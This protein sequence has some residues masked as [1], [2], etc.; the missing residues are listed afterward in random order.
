MSGFRDRVAVITGSGTGI[1]C[2]AAKVLAERGATV[3]VA[4][5]DPQSG[6]QATEAL[7]SAGLTARFIQT[8]VADS[9]SIEAMVTE[10]VAAFGRIDILINN[11]GV[12]I[13]EPFDTLTLEHW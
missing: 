6:A 4:E 11:V 3:V 13:R 12:T 5:I 10:A 2:A 1:G 7:T 8:D 9:T